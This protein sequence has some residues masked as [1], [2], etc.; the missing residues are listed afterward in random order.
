MTL[1]L[2]RARLY[3]AVEPACSRARPIPY[4]RQHIFRDVR[5]FASTHENGT[6]TTIDYQRWCH[7]DFMYPCTLENDE[8]P[9][10]RTLVSS[11][12]ARLQ[13]GT[14]YPLS[15]PTFVAA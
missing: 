9:P 10:V 2:R 5:V 15:L 13:H 8:K 12:G 4:P 1:N 14:R 6:D 3:R 7:Y 11:H